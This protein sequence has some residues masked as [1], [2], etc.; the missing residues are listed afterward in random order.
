MLIRSAFW[1]GA[2]LAG[3]EQIFRKTMDGLLAPTLAALPGVEAVHILWPETLE[4]DPPQIACQVLVEFD[5]RDD[6]TLMLASPE[7]A[8]M[9]EQVG[10]L[11]TLF[12]GRLSHIE[13]E[14]VKG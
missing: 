4:D 9:R 7:R 14:V 11:K 10:E 13:Y 1:V 2:P 3:N 5:S 12:G 8:K 6:L